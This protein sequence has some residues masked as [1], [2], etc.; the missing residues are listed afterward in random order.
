MD[1]HTL[2]RSV[3]LKTKIEEFVPTSSYDPRFFVLRKLFVDSFEDIDRQL[4]EQLNPRPKTNLT[5]W[6]EET[7]DEQQTMILSKQYRCFL[8]TDVDRTDTNENILAFLTLTEKDD[9]QI[10]IGQVAVRR[11][12]QRRGY[13]RQL[14]Q[15]IL[16]RYPKNTRYR[17]IIRRA[18]QPALQFFV[19]HGATFLDNHL[20]ATEYGYDP[21]LYVGFQFFETI[22]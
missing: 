18:N 9:K 19:K 1:Q 2:S 15:H 16:D 10:Y 14:F 12:V 22:P 21:A 20:L 5:Q 7:F 6:I 11:D 17:G 4:E 13:A 3:G 8:L